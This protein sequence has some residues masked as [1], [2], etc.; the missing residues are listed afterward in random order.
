MDCILGVPFLWL[1]DRASGS[2]SR[3]LEGGGVL[4]PSLLGGL[5][6]GAILSSC[7]FKPGNVKSLPVLPPWDPVPSLLLPLK[8]LNGIV[9]ELLIGQLISYQSSD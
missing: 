3:K 4:A 7:P 2:T 1:L 6:W 5:A 8:L 9:V